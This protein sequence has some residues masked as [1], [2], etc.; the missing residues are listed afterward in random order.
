MSSGPMSM[1]LIERLSVSG[2][3]PAGGAA[4]SAPARARAASPSDRLWRGWGRPKRG[5]LRP[6]GRFHGDPTGRRASM[7]S[8]ASPARPLAPPR[9]PAYPRRR[10]PVELRPAA[11][12]HGIPSM[13]PPPKLPIVA[14]VGRP[15]VGK[16]TLFNRYAGFRRALVED[17]PGVTRDTIAH[18]V[19]VAPG[20]SLL[21]VD[22]AGLD[23]DPEEG[24]PAAVQAQAR[25]EMAQADARLFAVDGSAGLVPVEATLARSLHRSAKPV[26]LVVNK[27][28]H[29]NHLGRVAEFARLGFASVHAVSEEHGSG[30]WDALEDPAARLP[31]PPAAHPGER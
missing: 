21:L 2:L 20:R 14:I 9:E 11:G 16:S 5:L 31:A 1:L 6:R 13:S 7:S 24:L 10:A 25:D 17:E 18:E 22:T 12:G 26:T 3:A 30:A 15:N 27:I 8:A 19:E 28:D 29:P 4:T 23:P